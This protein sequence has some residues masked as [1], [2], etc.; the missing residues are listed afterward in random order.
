MNPKSLNLSCD[1]FAKV[2]L[3]HARLGPILVDFI[4]VLY[5]LLHHFFT[6]NLLFD[7]EDILLKWKKETL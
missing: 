7:T 3:P 2:A 6:D 1:S 4:L 5:D